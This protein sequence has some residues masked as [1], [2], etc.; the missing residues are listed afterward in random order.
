MS[1][2]SWKAHKSIRSRL[3]E[4]LLY[5]VLQYEIKCDVSITEAYKIQQIFDRRDQ[6]TFIWDVGK[7]KSVKQVFIGKHGTY[8]LTINKVYDSKISGIIFVVVVGW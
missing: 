3:Y 2:A 4:V 1:S 7:K 6:E 5:T 8:Y